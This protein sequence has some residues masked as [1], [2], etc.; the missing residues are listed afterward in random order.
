[1]RPSKIIQNFLQLLYP[2]LCVGCST[3]LIYQEEDFCLH[4]NNNLPYTKIFSLQN[5][6]IIRRLS[7][8]INL[9]WAY[10]HLYFEKESI[11]Q[12]ILHDIKYNHNKELALKFG[13]EIGL[14]LSSLLE[15]NPSYIIQAVPLHPKK[16]KIR[17]FN[18]SLYL[19]KGISEI[20]GIPIAKK[21]L[22]RIKFRDSQTHKN[23]SE[24]WTQIQK[25]FF[26]EKT[27]EIM[28]KN[29]ILVDDI[30]TTG[31]TTEICSRVLLE[32]GASSIS[33]ITLAIAV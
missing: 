30:F 14:H 1:M 10:G 18:Q 7:S 23:R 16:E 33:I 20:L 8:R 13:K 24:R 3:I 2:Q 6:E 29:V 22:S 26:V 17:G 9:N 27:D 12:N 11:T 19:A 32:A 5:N 31:A 21:G 4:C 25:D 28:K 15:I